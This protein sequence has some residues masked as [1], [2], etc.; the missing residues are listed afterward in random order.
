MLFPD[1]SAP[2]INNSKQF[3]Q[4]PAIAFVVDRFI[5]LI[6]DFLIISPTVSLLI[7]GLVRQSKTFFLLNSQSEY[8]VAAVGLIF[9]VSTVIVVLM[10]ALS[11]Y[12][13]QATPGQYFLQLRVI[14]YPQPQERLSPSQ[15]LVRATA[16]CGTFLLFALPFL[17]VLSHPLRRAFHEKAS[18]TMVVT[19]KKQHDTGPK[20]LEQRVM[21][22]WLRLSFSFFALFGFVALVKSY[23][24]LSLPNYQVA[25]EAG[26]SA[27]KEIKDRELHGP[28]RL[29]AALSLFLL[30]EISAD[31]LNKE[32]ELSLWGDPVN[33]QSM[34]YFAKFLLSEGT[35]RTDYLSKVCEEKTSTGCVLAQYLDN[36][37]DIK[38]A[39][40]S[41]KLWVT[42]ILE[43]EQR[44]NQHD[45]VGSL[46]VIDELQSVTALRQA[47][48]KKYVRSIWG[49]QRS[50]N[51]KRGRAPAS[52]ETKPWLEDFKEKYGVQ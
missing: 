1:L 35:E 11:L 16:W 29:D 17:E 10:Q 14:S 4:E 30:K 37:D 43:A 7:A 49:L 51:E 18:D 42:Q 25:A 41:H 27:C 50:S 2:E 52:V 6:L 33:S 36:P 44:Y 48:D 38:L 15:C 40:A 45:Y 32:A 3:K 39:D 20:P 13:W 26:V 34:A 28:E 12:F 19:L 9:V 24:T 23:N 5:A 47:L 46:E 8:G 31:C 21:G 22:S